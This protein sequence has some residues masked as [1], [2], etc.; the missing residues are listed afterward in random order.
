MFVNMSFDMK[1]IKHNKKTWQSQFMFSGHWS[2]LIISIS[3]NIYMVFCLSS[4]TSLPLLSMVKNCVK[5]LNLLTFCFNFVMTC[6]PMEHRM[7]LLD[8]PFYY[9]TF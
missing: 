3:K 5:S 1:F 9:M 6:Q 7:S 8:N 2:S 4:N